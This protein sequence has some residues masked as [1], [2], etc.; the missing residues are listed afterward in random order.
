MANRTTPYLDYNYLLEL[1]PGGFSQINGGFSEVSGLDAEIAEAEYRPGAAQENHSD[2]YPGVYR[3]GDVTLKRGLIDAADILG[4]VEAVRAKGFQGNKDCVR[5]TRL[6]ESRNPSARWTL[7][8]VSPKKL[9][10]LTLAVKGGADVAMEELIL[11]VETI[12]VMPI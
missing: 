6:D 8:S 1:A 12:E 2:K 3:S 4:W 10:G 11:S 9:T 5:I 7:R